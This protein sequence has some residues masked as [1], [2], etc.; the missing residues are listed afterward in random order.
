MLRGARTSAVGRSLTSTVSTRGQPSAPTSTRTPRRMAPPAR[1]Y[2]K[3]PFLRRLG[4]EPENNPGVYNG[5]WG[6]RGPL[7]TS[8]NP[9]DG[10]PIATIRSATLEDHEETVRRMQA[11]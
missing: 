2:D 11:A 6:G 5:A 9:A 1:T 3:S 10:K 7:V 8:Y 4:I